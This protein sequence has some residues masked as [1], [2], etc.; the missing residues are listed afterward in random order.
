MLECAEITDPSISV[1]VEPV[2]IKS[3]RGALNKQA[4]SEKVE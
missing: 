1:L 2:N 4:L 3:L